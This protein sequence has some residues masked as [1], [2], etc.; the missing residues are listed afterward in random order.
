MVRMSSPRTPEEIAREAVDRFAEGYPDLW[1]PEARAF[2]SKSGLEDEVRGMIAAAIAADR[3]AAEAEKRAAVEAEREA[4]EAALAAVMKDFI[5]R[6][7]ASA[8]LGAS[9]AGSAALEAIRAR[10]KA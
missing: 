9:L 5:T 2:F 10:G 7:E 3:A 8:A 4:C 6:L 1:P